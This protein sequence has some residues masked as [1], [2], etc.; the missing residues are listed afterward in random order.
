MVGFHAF[1]VFL[2]ISNLHS[3]RTYAQCEL[4]AL[5]CGSASP[6][7]AETD[8]KKTTSLRSVANN[9]KNEIEISEEL[10]H[11]KLELKLI[12]DI[13]SIK[14]YIDRLKFKVKQKQNILINNRN[15]N[16]LSQ[17]KQKELINEIQSYQTLIINAIAEYDF[18]ANIDIKTFNPNKAHMDHIKKCEDI[19]SLLKLRYDWRDIPHDR[20]SM[21]WDP[22]TKGW[23]DKNSAQYG[24]KSYILKHA[25]LNKPKKHEYPYILLG[26]IH[27]RI[28]APAEF[29]YGF[30]KLV[31]ELKNNS[32]SYSIWGDIQ[33]S[34]IHNYY[35]YINDKQLNDEYEAFKR[36]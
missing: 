27:D 3:E 28:N 20:A 17:M 2:S 31:T 10:K 34:D 18:V 24:L 32:N 15:N 23:F 21:K 8:K 12:N 9:N 1:L 6:L 25:R 19:T 4:E 5:P 26:N 13:E 33:E 22:V 7:S 14:L 36:F 35:T 29:D 16:N 11:D 30:G